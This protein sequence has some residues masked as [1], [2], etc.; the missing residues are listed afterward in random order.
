MRSERDALVSS[1][2]VDWTTEEVET[3]T[4]LL[5]RFSTDLEHHRP[6]LLKTFDAQERP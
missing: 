1:V 4:R 3:L 2:L 5:D 6:R